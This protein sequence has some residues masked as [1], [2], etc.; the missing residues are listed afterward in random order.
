MDLNKIFDYKTDERK[1]RKLAVNGLNLLL[2]AQQERTKLAQN[3]DYA[4]FYAEQNGKLPAEAQA[5]FTQM[6]TLVSQLHL[7]MWQLHTGYRAIEP[8]SDLFPGIS[9]PEP[10]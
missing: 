4:P 10:E 2:L 1:T 9:E 3:P 8:G 5:A 6:E 7:V